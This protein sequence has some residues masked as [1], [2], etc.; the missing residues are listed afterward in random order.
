MPD[1]NDRNMLRQLS[2]WFDQWFCH[3][4]ESDERPEIKM[5]RMLIA[6][7]GPEYS[8]QCQDTNQVFDSMPL[9]EVEVHPVVKDLEVQKLAWVQVVEYGGA[10]FV[11][12][13]NDCDGDAAARYSLAWVK[14]FAKVEVREAEGETWIEQ[15]ALRERYNDQDSEIMKNFEVH[16]AKSCLYIE[17]LE[18]AKLS[19]YRIGR[20]AWMARFG[21]KVDSQEYRLERLFLGT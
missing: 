3:G 14:H 18:S 1:V 15:V 20:L 8:A 17:L 7:A 11:V 12:G 2:H 4:G 10:A 16:Q 9:G 5:K 21:K 19:W 6:S 13:E